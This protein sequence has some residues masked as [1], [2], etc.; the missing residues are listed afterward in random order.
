MKEQILTISSI[1]K[2]QDDIFKTVLIGDCSEISAPGQFINIK[3][4]GF[5]L[6]RPVSIADY[7]ENS[8]TIIYKTVGKGTKYMS[9]LPVGKSLQVLMPL[10]NGFSLEK[11]EKALSHSLSDAAAPVLIG[12]GIGLPPIFSLAKVLMKR[13]I[14]PV[15]IAGF[16][17]KSDVILENEFKAI[18]I[19]PIITTVDGTYGK[20][21]LVTEPFSELLLKLHRAYVCT[22]GPEPMLKAIHQLAADGQFSFEARMACGFGACMGCSCKTK[23]GNKRIC[24]DG[25]ILEKEEII[26]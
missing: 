18:G 25:P 13:G 26:W 12:G 8:L 10:G 6:R 21:G 20:K 5:F 3:L 7:T 22:C 9:T 4:N 24:T 2:L 19:S 1:E 14:T 15:V 23:Y 16:N 11:I 17:S